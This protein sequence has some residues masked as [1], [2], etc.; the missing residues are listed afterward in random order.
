MTKVEELQAQMVAPLVVAPMFTIT[1][2]NLV[3][4]SCKAG[5]IGVY[6][7]LNSRTSE[8]FEEL[9]KE[10]T[11]ELRDYRNANPDAIVAPYAVNLVLRGTNTRLEADLEICERYKVPIVITIMGK[12]GEVA[13][14][15][16]AYGGLVFSDVT[17]IDFAKKAAG[18][19]VDG[20]ILICSGAGGHA[21]RLSPFA[22]IPAVREFFDGI[23]IGGG[24]V[25]SGGAVRAVQALG[26]DLAYMGTRFIPTVECL[27]QEPYKQMIVDSTIHDIIYTPAVSGLP[28][29]FMRAS[30]ETAGFDLSNPDDIQRTDS[31]NEAKAW[32]G[33]WGAGQGV[34]IVHEVATVSDLVSKLKTE[35]EDACSV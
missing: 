25:S 6:P 19:G 26:G 35:Y 11:T 14:R 22:F 13:E 32:S 5:V 16:H 15:V 1:G 8:D 10:L 21:G 28:A 27:A 23:I 12:P 17:T 31:S 4:E 34:H 29:N 33:I 30:L 3:V 2:L 9:L 24:C 20:L 7:A 18:G